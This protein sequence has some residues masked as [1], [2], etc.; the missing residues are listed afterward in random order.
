MLPSRFL[1]ESKLAEMKW[2]LKTNRVEGINRVSAFIFEHAR[3]WLGAL[4]PLFA[5]LNRL[6]AS[7]YSNHPQHFQVALKHTNE[8]L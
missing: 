5:Q 7:Y 8:S 6:L 1:Y 4:H 2:F 3:K